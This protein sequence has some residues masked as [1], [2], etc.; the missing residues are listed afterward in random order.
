MELK[1]SQSTWAAFGKDVARLRLLSGLLGD[2]DQAVVLAY[3]TAPLTAKEQVRDFQ[4][5]LKATDLQQGEVKV[6]P[7][8][9]VGEGT[10]TRMAYAYMYIIER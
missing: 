9:P 6:L 1:G 10:Q 5:F 4:A 2:G 8:L 7:K 3:V